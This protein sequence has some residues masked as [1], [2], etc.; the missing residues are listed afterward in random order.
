MYPCA[1]PFLPAPQT[2]EGE[3]RQD[4]FSEWGVSERLASCSQHLRGNH[5]R[6]RERK[7][8]AVRREGPARR[9]G[10]LGDGSGWEPPDSPLQPPPQGPAAEGLVR[11]AFEKRTYSPL[12]RLGVRQAIGDPAVACVKCPPGKRHLSRMCVRG[13]GKHRPREDVQ[14]RLIMLAGPSTGGTQPDSTDRS[15]SAPHVRHRH[16]RTASPAQEHSGLMLFSQPGAPS[17]WDAAPCVRPSPA[18]QWVDLALQDR[19]RHLNES[20]IWSGPLS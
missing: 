12:W 20:P 17:S 7:R 13:C 9:R 10:P 1:S 5:H 15:P 6:E 14:P 4:V 19:S 2:G 18:P 8:W 11:K 16:G 3:L